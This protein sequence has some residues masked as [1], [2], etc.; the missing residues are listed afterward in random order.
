ML[1]LSHLATITVIFL[2]SIAACK[3]DTGLFGLTFNDIFAATGRATAVS[4]VF[5]PA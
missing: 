5:L 1:P 3:T 2:L 4:E